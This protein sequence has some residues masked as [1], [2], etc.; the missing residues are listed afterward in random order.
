MRPDAVVE[1]T[2]SASDANPTPRSSSSAIALARCRLER[3]KRSSFAT[4]ITSTFPSRHSPIRL[5]VE[6]ASWISYRRTRES[7]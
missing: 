6:C 2:D 7:P 1:S 5:F 4:T 3:V